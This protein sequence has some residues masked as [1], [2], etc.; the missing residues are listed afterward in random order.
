MSASAPA[1]WLDDASA[2]IPDLAPLHRRGFGG[3]G[4][5]VLAPVIALVALAIRLRLGAPVVFWHSSVWACTENRSSFTS[6]APS[7]Q[8]LMRTGVSCRG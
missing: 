4:L 3:A 1:M 8:P 7:G 2:A 5:I 6:S